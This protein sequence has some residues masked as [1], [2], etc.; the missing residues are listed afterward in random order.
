[1]VTEKS[2][3]IGA[4]AGTIRDTNPGLDKTIDTE[5][6][7]PN[8]PASIERSITEC[9]DMFPCRVAMLELPR[10]GARQMQ[11]FGEGHD[12]DSGMTP[13]KRHRYQESK[14]QPETEMS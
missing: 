5:L 9:A 8:R 2:E 1:M 13:F 3:L 10:F 14:Y 12:V 4:K 11:S 7:R 6:L